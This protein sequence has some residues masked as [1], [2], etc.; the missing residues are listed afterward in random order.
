MVVLSKIGF[1]AATA[2][3]NRELF[4][5]PV[6]PGFLSQQ[7]AARPAA[8]AY[9]SSYGYTPYSDL[10]AVSMQPQTYGEPVYASPNGFEYVA[11][12][13][14]AQG[15]GWPA[16]LGF[17][18]AGA[19]AGRAIGEHF[20]GSENSEVATLAV[21]GQ[22]AFAPSFASRVGTPVMAVKNPK[23]VVGAKAKAPVRKATPAKR[24]TTAP[25]EKKVPRKF[26]PKD[27]DQLF[28]YGLPGAIPPLGPWDPLGLLKGR[29][30]EEVIRSREVE[31]THGRIGMLASAGF[32]VQE[33]FHPLFGGN[34]DGAAV[35]Q[36][37]KIPIAFWV[38]AAT[39]IGIL[40]S[41]RL[42]ASFVN[43]YESSDGK[44]NKL[45]PDY[46]PGDLNFD[47]LG[48]KPTDPAEF[49]A[50]QERELSHGRLGMIASIIFIGQEVKDQQPWLDA[51]GG[52]DDG[53]YKAVA[54]GFAPVVIGLLLAGFS[55]DSKKARA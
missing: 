8:Y 23:A 17:V 4:Q 24:K 32:F 19:L 5:V 28:C 25:A 21:S 13:Q 27:Q 1:L 15:W 29:T 39:A 26:L 2:S 42:Q 33:Q 50:M 6:N 10:P 36:I 16:V 49:R 44:S 40:E 51:Y 48:I 22:Q 20:S 54:A 52:V 47:P 12:E 53:G 41:S 30:K 18:A 34:L 3:A 35:D 45:K 55:A 11:Y 43:P 38:L 46:M 7:T 9:D 31:L 14:P 37:P